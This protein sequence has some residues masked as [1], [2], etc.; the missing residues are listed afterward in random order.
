MNLLDEFNL[1][2][3]TQ[4]GKGSPWDDSSFNYLTAPWFWNTDMGVF[5]NVPFTKDGKRYIQF[6][7]E[8]YNIMNHTNWGGVNGTV[9]FAAL[10]TAAPRET[11]PTCPSTCCRQ[12]PHQTADVSAPA[13][14][15]VLAAAASEKCR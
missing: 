13:P 12:A 3:V 8:F 10:G 11:S 6:R 15:R 5:K 14:R 1:A 4:A 7:I 9:Q 2:A